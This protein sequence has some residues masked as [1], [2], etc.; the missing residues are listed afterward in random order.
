VAPRSVAAVKHLVRSIKMSAAREAA[1]AALRAGTA[2][3]AEALLRE[4]LLLELKR[5]GDAVDG[6]L[7]LVDGHILP[8]IG[9]N[10]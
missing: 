8:D 2:P 6:L 10:H 7:A 4:R 1:Q 9:D 3:A 5:H